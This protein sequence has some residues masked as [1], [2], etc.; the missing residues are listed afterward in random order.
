MIKCSVWVELDVGGT[1]RWGGVVV[2]VV[3][4]AA[5]KARMGQRQ[6]LVEGGRVARLGAG[7]RAQSGNP[8]HGTAA[9][10]ARGFAASLYREE[11]ARGPRHL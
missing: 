4:Y 11:A 1:R 8:A 6:Q 9:A 10:V 7:N 5:S 3:V 2:L